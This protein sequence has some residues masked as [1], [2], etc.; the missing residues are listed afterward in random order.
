[1]R[2]SILDPLFAP[3][4]ALPGVGP[5]MAALYDR[6]LG[7]PGK[8]ARVI[9]VLFHLP[10]AGISRRASGSIQDAP[11][12]EVATF[13]AQVSEHRPSPPG[14]ARAPYRVVMEDETGDV[15]LVFFNADSRRMAQLLP[16]GEIRWV[17]GKIELWDGRRQMV[18][19]DRVMDARAFQAMPSVEAVYGMTEGLSSRIFGKAAE[20]AIG[21][22]AP[23]PEWQD[24]AWMRRN[25]FPPFPDAL[26]AMHRPD[27]V[28]ALEPANP[29]RRRLAYDE[30]LASQLALA[31]V[32]ASHRKAA[33]RRNSGDGRLVKALAAALP[34][35]LTTS[36]KT[37]VEQIR[38]DLEKPERMLRLLQGDV[39]SGKTAV[40]MMAMASAAEVGRQSALMA[41]T[42]IL[43]RQHAERLGPLA[44]AIGLRLA[45]LTGREKGE[46][47]QAVLSGLATA[48]STASSART[49]S[50][51]STSNSTILE[52][53]SW[54]S[55][56]ASA[57]TSAS[58]SA[59]RARPST[60]W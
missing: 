60:C 39:G 11:I 9:D 48:T 57:C 58:P 41:P 3:V 23:L 51:R 49:L 56:I 28:E 37:A 35:E 20:G 25:A 17:S 8:P 44:S 32:R 19:P 55:S 42:E 33:G 29:S 30:L 14:R 38:A 22:V 16:V 26:A 12:G 47:R 24:E 18:H 10:H 54:T 7:E 15:T 31:L 1:M 40:A 46:A 53:R 6:L 36:Q 13:A 5:K 50:S 43:A 34:Y 59:R 21:R 45:L 52:S 27:A 2:P 4:T